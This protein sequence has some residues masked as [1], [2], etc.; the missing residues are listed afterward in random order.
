MWN[1]VNNGTLNHF[2]RCSD[3]RCSSHRGT[4]YAFKINNFCRS[5]ASWDGPVS[6]PHLRHFQ[7]TVKEFGE[8]SLIDK[9]E[10]A[11][12]LPGQRQSQCAA[13]L[14]QEIEDRSRFS[15]ESPLH[16]HVIQIYQS[17]LGLASLILISSQIRRTIRLRPNFDAPSIS[18]SFFRPCLFKYTSTSLSLI[19]VDRF[20][21]L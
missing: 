18:D 3:L 1:E 10:A 12:V 4:P 8:I 7:D 13:E 19:I 16:F 17:V 21:M 9:A 15:E 5:L 11:L 14:R 6:K 2:W 20:S